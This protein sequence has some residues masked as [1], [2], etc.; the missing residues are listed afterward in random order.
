MT[1]QLL[2][3]PARPGQV[4]RLAITAIAPVVWGTTYVVTTELLPPNHPLFASLV[5]ALPAG[6]LGLALARTLPCGV[7]WVRAAI[8]G[9]L[10]IGLFF[11]LLFVAAERL[12]GGVAATLS[13]TQPVIV[14]GLAVLLLRERPSAW[15]IGW[16]VAGVVGV[17]MVVLRPNAAAF[18]LVGALAALGSA[19]SMA[20]GVVLTTRW[21]RPDGVSATAFASWL[22]TAGGLVLLPVTLVVEGAPPSVDGPAVLGFLWLGLVGG[23]LAYM[24]WFRGLATLPVTSIALLS[25]LSPVVA[26]LLGVLVL[27]Q[28]LGSVQLVGFALA[29]VSVT[30]GQWTPPARSTSSLRDVDP[31][32]HGRRDRSGEATHSP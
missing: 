28:T 7:W 1:S 18:D 5:R 6:L 13:A 11:P 4:G 16:A 32:E 3:P 31:N 22:L 19:V 26:A 30:A 15:R 21:G 9:V 25:P 20:L 24:L 27:H 17:A 10:N 23:L 2:P 14:V 12:P 8:L 29:L